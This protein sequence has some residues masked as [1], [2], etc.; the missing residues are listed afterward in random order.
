MSFKQEC[1]IVINFEDVADR[2]VITRAIR[3]L[4]EPEFEKLIKSIKISKEEKQKFKDLS[5]INAEIRIIPKRE[6]IESISR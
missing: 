6:Y 1:Y 5:G 2:V 3:E 4:L